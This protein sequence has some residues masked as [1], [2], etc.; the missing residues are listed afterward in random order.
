MKSLF[1]SK[2]FWGATVSLLPAVVPSA[3]DIAQGGANAQNVST[4]AAALAG[5]GFTLFGRTQAN[6][7]V[8]T[9]NW[10]PGPNRPTEPATGAGF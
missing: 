1:A 6:Q 7:A 9:P 10:M 8:Y 4:I 3:F 2:T 5:Y